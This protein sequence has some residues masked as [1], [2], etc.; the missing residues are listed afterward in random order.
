[1]KNQ[2]LVSYPP[3]I[4][5]PL[6]VGSEISDLCKLLDDFY[7][8]YPLQH[9]RQQASDILKGAFYAARQE[10]RSNPDWM[11][12]SANS[13]RDI[14]Y[15]LLR[16]QT[17]IDNLIKLFKE[18]AKNFR[19]Q[20]KNKEFVFT[21]SKLEI[22]YKKL[23]DITH[24]GTDLHGFK[25]EQKFLNFSE[26]DYLKL[27]EE[28]ALILKQA[29]SYQQLYIHTIIDVIIKSEINKKL[30]NK[31]SLILG[32]NEDAKQYFFS[33][34]DEN[35]LEWLWENDFLQ[36]IKLKAKDQNSYNFRTPELN[37]LVNVAEKKPD[38]ATKIICSFQI[39]KNNFNPE[40]V[41]QFVRICGKLPPQ[42]LKDV[43]KK[44]RDENWIKLMGKYTQYGFDYDDMLETLHEAN[45]FESILILAEAMFTVRTKEELKES[46]VKYR[47]D[48][49]FYIHD[50]SETK[51]FVYLVEMPNQY[52][53]KALLLVINTF[54][55]AIKN[56]GNYLLMDEDFFT[57]RLNGLI[58]NHYGEDCKFLTASIIELV[59]KI[60]GNLSLESKE[61]YSKYFAKLP[62]SQITRRLKLF[63]LSLDPKLFIK[64]LKTEYFNLFKVTKIFDVLY[65]AEY[66]RA[67]KAG[68]SYLNNENKRKYISNVLKLFSNYKGEED[69]RWKRHYASCILS[70]ISKS[71]TKDEIAL[72]NI[73]DFKID[74][75]YE[76]E[77]SIGRIR[78]GT[79]TPRSPLS[80]DDFSV[81]TIADVA[82]KLKK[83]LS[84]S[85]LKKKYKDDDFLNPRDADGVA[86]QLKSDIKN[87]INVYLKNATLFF[88]REKLIPH[89]TNAYLRGIRDS[90]SE[91]RSEVDNLDYEELFELLLMIK[92]SGEEKLFRKSEDRWI[93]NWESVLSTISDLLEEL[94]KQKDKKTLLNFKLY[95]NKVLEILSYLFNFDDPI[96]EDE[97]IK[98]ARMT[99]KRSNESE[100]FTSDPF[101]IAIN[102]IR[103]RAF[104]ILL[105]FIYQDAINFKNSQLAD[106]VKILYEKLLEK[107]KT[108]AIMFMFGHYLHSFYFRDKKWIMNRFNEIFEFKKKDKYLH[109]AAWE[110]YLSSN[111][112]S[113]LFFD[114]YLQKLYKKN[115]TLNQ[116]YPKQK[117]F[118]DP[119]ESL[120]IHFALAFVHYEE[121]GFDHKLFKKFLNK[122][123]I[124][125]LSEFINFL[126]RSYLAGE[127]YNILKDIQFPWRI[128]RVE[129]FW[130][131]MIKFKSNSPSLKEFGTW[132]D[133]RHEVFDVKWLA[134]TI[135]QNLNVTKGELEWSYG[136]M[137]SIEKLAEQSPVNALQILEKYFLLSTQK[138]GPF[139]IRADKDWYNAFKILYENKN[140][141]IEDSTYS[142][143]NKLI[144][145]GG[146]SFWSLE[147]IIKNK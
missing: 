83:E 46:K 112:Y 52:L 85:E 54:T 42:R 2:N 100:Y 1:M 121:F 4:L 65:G 128:K 58:G 16:S 127:N 138:D 84:P 97:K 51:I 81:L 66:E 45:D 147:N 120:A 116:Q 132:I 140:K 145:K 92:K 19:S 90:L 101:S 125:Q 7:R 32:S 94:I 82:K 62:K 130:E 40:V 27:L 146:R 87:R 141:K 142:L 72:A 95:R 107:E 38:F 122:A 23:S 60:I 18:Y 73:N 144:E 114:P 34:A 33:K 15:P 134:K 91:K 5:S 61:I 50:L 123:T 102:S 9:K 25:S 135:C 59:R 124:K 30:I 69:K 3:F 117:F 14:L 63:T 53:E 29:L 71:L 13:A 12:Q 108:R 44:I 133:V 68:F 43:V 6:V 137:K 106:D 136:L 113:E 96:P 17:G 118:K 89:Y 143:I 103:G 131:F 67:L 93:S 10:C 31:V 11:S 129:D 115:I 21:F 126:G 37:Y 119:Q 79:V 35:W 104:Q 39:S 78:G 99:T 77:P 36:V 41:D 75:K 111:L 47:S 64:E 70:T 76:P 20:I 8:T 139:Y 55:K 24:H 48:G 86:E 74:P 80:S 22:I 57:L 26:K 109:L 28:F 105:H 98:T 49:I 56:E 110:G 88:D